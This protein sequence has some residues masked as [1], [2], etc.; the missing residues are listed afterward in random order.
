MFHAVTYTLTVSP[1]SNE[2]QYPNNQKEY[3]IPFYFV[4][5][6]GFAA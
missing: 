6:V 5:Q 4:T 3:F 1:D 2:V